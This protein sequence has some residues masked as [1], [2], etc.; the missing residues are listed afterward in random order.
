M[1]ETV[2]AGP[3]AVIAAVRAGEHSDDDTRRDLDVRFGWRDGKVRW[4]QR[5][6]AAIAMFAPERFD[7]GVVLTIVPAPQAD[8]TDR[9]SAA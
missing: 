8:R 3:A 2:M 4:R 5:V 6:P 7:D 9:A 1:F